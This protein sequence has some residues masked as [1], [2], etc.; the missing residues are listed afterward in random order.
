MNPFWIIKKFWLFFN[1]NIKHLLLRI[2]HLLLRIKHL[3]LRI[4]HFLPY[5]VSTS[6]LIRFKSRG[7]VAIDS[8]NW[9]LIWASKE[10]TLGKLFK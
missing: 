2:K 9:G 8:G 3:L 7:K 4:K 10:V 6:R 1:I 5:S